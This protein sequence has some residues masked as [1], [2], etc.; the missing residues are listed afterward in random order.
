MI[1]AHEPDQ[2]HR[3]PV[4]SRVRRLR[5][6]AEGRLAGK[7]PGRERQGIRTCA[8]GVRSG[9]GCGPGAH[10][11]VRGRDRA[12]GR[13]AQGS[14]QPRRQIRD[15]DRD[16]RQ[17]RRPDPG[18]RDR[19]VHRPQCDVAADCPPQARHGGP[20]PQ[21][22]QDEVPEKDRRDEIGDMARTVEIFKTNGIEVERLK[23]AQAEVEKQAADQR[24]R[25]MVNLADGFERAVGEIIETVGSASTEL[26]ASSS[27]LATTA[28]RAQEL[29]SVVAVAWVK[30]PATCSRLRPPRELSSS[31]NEISR[32]VQESRGWRCEAV[33]QART[34]TERVSELSVAAT[35]IGDVV[36]LINGH[37][38]PDERAAGVHSRRSI[39]DRGRRR[40]ATA[41]AARLDRRAGQDGDMAAAACGR[42]DASADRGPR[43]PQCA[44]CRLRDGAS[45]ASCSAP[46]RTIGR[47]D[48]ARCSRVARIGPRATTG[49]AAATLEIM[50][51]YDLVS[52]TPPTAYPQSRTAIAD[53]AAL[54]PSGTLLSRNLTSPIAP[55]R[56]T[57]WTR[58]CDGACA[59]P[60]ILQT[61]GRSG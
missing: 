35:R 18:Y 61:S 34:T 33:A 14:H 12:G 49:M 6:G 27:T 48:R 53:V 39:H 37:C 42:A 58:D 52:A 30:P 56:P 43:L 41:S 19:A 29:T 17:R 32:Q 16:R 57:G 38:R 31:V 55:A 7:Q 23:A 24:K 51:A 40:P 3:R 21:R 20:C 5:S 60:S 13:Q 54:R 4:E 1:R 22:S 36:E 28:Q 15:L 44:R 9:D 50:R 46:I 8:Q 25:D 11:P 26:E 47:D 10:R 45:A 2:E 59:S